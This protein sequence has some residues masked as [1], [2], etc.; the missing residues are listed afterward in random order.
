[1]NMNELASKLWPFLARLFM[2]SSSAYGP[3]Y[4]GGATGGTTTY[5]VQEGE[6]IR[7]GNVL[8]CWGRVVWTNATGTGSARISLPFACANVG[9][10]TGSL[11]LDSVTFTTTSPEIIVSVGNSY[12]EMYSPA[13][14]AASNLVT[15]E[16]AGTIIWQITYAMS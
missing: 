7:I 4:Q 1:M 3:T 6:W 9:R 13:S 12:F 14:N 11:F 5:T 15:I 10:A 8:V 2:D 16:T